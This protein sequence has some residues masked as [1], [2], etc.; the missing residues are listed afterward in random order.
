MAIVKESEESKISIRV[1]NGTNAAGG[2]VYKTMSFS[3][4]KPTATNQDIYDVGFG[5]AGLQSKSL[6]EIIR[7]DQASLISE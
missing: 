1:V 5:L 6:V 7:A 3:N 4:V 2:N